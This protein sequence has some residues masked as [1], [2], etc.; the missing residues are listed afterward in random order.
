M[1]ATVWT[2]SQQSVWFYNESIETTQIQVVELR[3]ISLFKQMKF[4]IPKFFIIFLEF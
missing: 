3:F 2:Y 1:I 4:L